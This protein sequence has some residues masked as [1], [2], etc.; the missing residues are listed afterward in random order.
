MTRSRLILLDAN[1]VIQLF[2][3]GIWE[4][5]TARCDIVLAQTVV[6]EVQFYETDAGREYVDWDHWKAKCSMRV[7]SLPAADIQAY[8]A[9]FGPG[10][11][12]KLDP[13]EAEALALLAQDAESKICS[14]DK[15]V[16]RVLGNTNAT[17]RGISLEEILTK[18]GLTKPLPPRFTKAFREKWCREGSV[19]G[20]MGQGDQ[21]RRDGGSGRPS[22]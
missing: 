13:G 21:T 1:V 18:S 5:I 2:Q 17:E 15:I 6:D 22:W 10:Y 16:W 8:C 9:S 7:E 3:L 12:E 19:E 11:Y 14:A 4:Q 20:F